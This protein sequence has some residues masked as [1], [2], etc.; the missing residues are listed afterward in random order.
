MGEAWLYKA[1]RE[2][3]SG[4]QNV[5]A[6]ADAFACDAFSFWA[7]LD[8]AFLETM[9]ALSRHLDLEFFSPFW[10]QLF[11]AYLDYRPSLEGSGFAALQAEPNSRAWENMRAGILSLTGEAYRRAIEE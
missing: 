11:Y 6:A 10:M 7:P 2:E 8:Q 1:S 3:L 5:A 9:C 4:G